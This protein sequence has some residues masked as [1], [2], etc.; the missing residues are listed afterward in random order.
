MLWIDRIHRWT[1]AFIGVLLAALGLTGTLLLYEDAWLRATVPHAEQPLVKDAAALGAAT[2]RMVAEAPSRPNG[3]IFPTDSVGLFKLSFEGGAGAYADQSGAIVLHWAS[4]W[5]RPEL[6]LTDFHQHLLLGESGATVAGILALIGLGFVITG[7][8]LWWRTRRTFALRLLPA[9]FTRVQ[10]ARHHRDLGAVMAPMLLVSLL[11]GAM[12][13]LRP[14]ADFVLA[15]LS[16]PGTIATSLA[17]PKAKGGPLTPAFDWGAALQAIHVAYPDAEL[18]SIGIPRREGELIRIRARQP[19]ERLPNGRT[20]FWFDAADGRV[21]ERRDALTLPLATRAFNLVYPLHVARVGG[22]VYLI[23]MT[24]AGLSLTLL[25]TLAVF[26]FWRYQA[27]QTVR[28]DAPLSRA[29]SHE[30]AR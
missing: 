19:A 18:R 9:R 28:S 30:T 21:V 22:L 5:Q 14:V 4:K 13:T 8:L 20:V 1:G 15:P 16:T 25:G 6:W 2:K 3:I 23:A 26:G 27:R 7:L 29:V 10:I 11:T 24:A 12:L 17:P